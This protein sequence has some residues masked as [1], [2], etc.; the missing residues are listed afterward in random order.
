[1]STTQ[2]NMVSK[3]KYDKIKSKGKK[4]YELAKKLKEDNEKL[5]KEKTEES[6]ISNKISNNTSNDVSELKKEVNH[7][8]ELLRVLK[9]HTNELMNKIRSL[10]KVIRTQQ[11]QIS[12][13]CKSGKIPKSDNSSDFDKDL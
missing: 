8:F 3:E 12:K 4:L 2:D 1:M 5:L 10:E 7:N 9:L 6:K 11:S 13:M